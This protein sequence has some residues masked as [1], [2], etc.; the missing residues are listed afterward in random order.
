[1][2]LVN[3]SGIAMLSGAGGGAT[4]TTRKAI[5]AGYTFVNS[6][7]AGGVILDYNDATS[8]NITVPSGITNTEP[9]TIIW[10][11]NIGQPTFVEGVGVTINTQDGKLKLRKSYSGANLIPSGNQDNIYDLLGDTDL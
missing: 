7:F 2:P 3:Y 11:G 10:S 8:G 6:D 5:S 1:M 4:P 9:C